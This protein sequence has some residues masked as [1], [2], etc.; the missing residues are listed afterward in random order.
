MDLPI[1]ETNSKPDPVELV[2]IGVKSL[3]ESEAKELED[4]VKSFNSLNEQQNEVFWSSVGKNI[5]KQ[6]SKK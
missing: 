4:Q 3:T 2:K 5:A 1:P 6:T